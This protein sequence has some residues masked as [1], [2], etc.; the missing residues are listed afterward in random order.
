MDGRIEQPAGRTR[1]GGSRAGF[2]APVVPAEVVPA[3]VAAPTVAAGVANDTVQKE[4][5]LSV[6][7]T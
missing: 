4:G 7:V 5:E 6:G 1:L 3:A 2:A